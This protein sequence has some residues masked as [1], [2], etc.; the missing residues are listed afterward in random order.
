[1]RDPLPALDPFLQE[2]RATISERDSNYWAA[3]AIR[4]GARSVVRVEI[5]EHALAELLRG[6]QVVHIANEF[7]C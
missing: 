3:I 1:M 7:F 2:H 6:N 5:T 4:Q